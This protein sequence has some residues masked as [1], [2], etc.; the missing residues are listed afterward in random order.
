MF[1]IVRV[2]EDTRPIYLK[3]KDK[4]QAQSFL[5]FTHL[6]TQESFDDNA[7]GS[8]W[9]SNDD[10]IVG[11]D[12]FTLETQ[13]HLDR[14]LID[15]MTFSIWQRRLALRAS[16][17]VKRGVEYKSCLPKFGVKNNAIIFSFDEN[18][19]PPRL[20]PDIGDLV[21]IV[22]NPNFDRVLGRVRKIKH[23]V[24]T[25]VRCSY[26]PLEED[27]LLPLVNVMKVHDFTI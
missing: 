9:H 26:S 16:Q 7:H 27:L 2:L 19:L 24:V 12:T 8:Y 20:Q 6:Y 17:K 5:D 4:K 3:F 10:S 13:S 18:S 14:D 22:G 15:Y 25:L 1:G 21:I 23:G 11:I